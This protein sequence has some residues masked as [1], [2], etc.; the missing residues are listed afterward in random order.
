[1]EPI[2][3]AGGEPEA[4]LQVLSRVHAVLL[5]GGGDV[6]PGRYGAG[7][8]PHQYGVDGERDELEV[9]VLQEARS[10]ELPILAECRGVQVV[11]VAFGGT[12]IQHLADVGGTVVHRDEGDQALAHEV[13]VS[14]GTRLAR[15]TGQEVITGR[16]H[17]HQALDRLGPGLVVSA[18]A[19]DGVV[20]AVESEQGWLLGVQWH[21]EETVDDDPAQQ[22]LFEALA[23]EAR[24]RVEADPERR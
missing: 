21:P 9:R 14:A 1:M 4:A 15:A 18:R 20:E 17:H 7:P 10:K 6:D 23:N 22:A 5:I 13:K 3:L 11:N 16:S 24:R 8:H 2:I 19:D 12:L